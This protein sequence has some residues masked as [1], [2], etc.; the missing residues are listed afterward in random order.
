M[1]L[2][3]LLAGSLLVAGCSSQG[4]PGPRP[5][6]SLSTL[7]PPATT[8]VPTS[9]TPCLPSVVGT[10]HGSVDALAISGA[11]LIVASDSRKEIAA[12]DLS[13][14]GASAPA[15][16][17]ASN[18]RE[19]FAVVVRGACVAWASAE[20]VFAARLDGQDRQPLLPSPDAVAIALGPS[21]L[22]VAIRNPPAI[23]RVSWPGTG[24]STVVV[25]GAT[26][27]ELVAEG[28][29]LAWS[30][31]SG[32]VT[33]YDLVKGVARTIAANHRKPHDLTVSGGILSWHEGEAE[34]LPGREPRAFTADLQ[35]GVVTP[36]VGA[37]DS[38]NRYILR[39][40]NIYGAA[41]CKATHEPT[42]HRLDTGEGEPPITDDAARW[43]WVRDRHDGSHEIVA[44]DKVACC[45]PAVHR[46]VEPNMPR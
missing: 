18:V 17:I 29:H 25:P 7:Q 32:S 23:W 33:T 42:F 44:A 22:F 14:S 6:A 28:D 26:A 19:P 27:D 10:F 5:P 2:L 35:T 9:N 30:D 40:T 1:N 13:P 16:V 39:G 37:R 24:A 8:V 36:A 41:V 21:D 45:P 20:G 11:E 43:Y 12:L 3:P 4:D 15:R 46:Q 34:L 31:V 38:F